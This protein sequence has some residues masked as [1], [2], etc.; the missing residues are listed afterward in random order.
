MPNQKI[1]N[2]NNKA[3]NAEVSRAVGVG[4]TDQLCARNITQTNQNPNGTTTTKTRNYHN[5]NKNKS[6]PHHKIAENIKTKIKQ[7]MKLQIR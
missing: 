7:R 4:L 1:K 2:S 6:Q 3:Y 5:T